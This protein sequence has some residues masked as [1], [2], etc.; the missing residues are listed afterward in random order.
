LEVPAVHERLYR[1]RDDRMLFGVAGG[2]ADWLD[3]DPAIV[4]I[5]WAL[6]IF[7]G[8]AGL[9]LYIVA[10]I[11]IPEEPL[12]RADIAVPMGSA[13]WGGSPPAAGAAAASG[14]AT[15]AEGAAPATGEATA[16]ASPVAPAAPMTAPAYPSRQAAREARRAERRAAR[17]QREG[18]GVLILG[19]ILIA[20]GG[21]LLARMYI[22]F[23]DDRI[24][25]PAFLVVVGILVLA[26]GLNRPRQSPPS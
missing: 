14:G 9:L 22:P 7:A 6:L 11:V 8:G 18:N 12:D 19:V 16:A 3:I 20:L 21:W 4:R 10:A 2:M 17:G 25:G 15:A 1:S 26:S 23:F 24:V 13:V 5:V